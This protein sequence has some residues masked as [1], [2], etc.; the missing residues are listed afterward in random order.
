MHAVLG[1]WTGAVSSRAVNA[2]SV[3]YSDFDNRISPVDPGVQLT[4]PSIQA[5]SS[6]RVPQATMQRRLVVYAIQH[7]LVTPS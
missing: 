4:F 5:G 2:L 1:S 3:S 7:G 6:F